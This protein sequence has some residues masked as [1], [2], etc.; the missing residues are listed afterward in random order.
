MADNLN[1]VI[2]M[3]SK[4]ANHVVTMY[5]NLE[6]IACIFAVQAGEPLP[7]RD[8]LEGVE[9]RENLLDT[10]EEVQQI[11]AN[12]FPEEEGACVDLRGEDNGQVGSCD[13]D[14]ESKDWYVYAL[15]NGG[16]AIRL[17]IEESREDAEEFV[18]VMLKRFGLQ[19]R[20]NSTIS[21]S[22]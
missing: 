1:A 8:E 14:A 6:Q 3:F 7:I 20:Q 16:Q 21:R 5:P 18:E 4:L 2:D 10:L 11:L 22:G 15:T 17:T 12:A 13:D 19:F 9:V